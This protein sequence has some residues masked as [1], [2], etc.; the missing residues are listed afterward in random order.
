MKLFDLELYLN[1]YLEVNRFK[2]YC[3]KG[4]IVEGH[5]DIFSGITGV[6]LSIELIE[7]AIAKNAN[8]IIVKT[9]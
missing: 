5:S 8:F 3:P 7:T 1:D 2:D 6:S 4:L 9:L